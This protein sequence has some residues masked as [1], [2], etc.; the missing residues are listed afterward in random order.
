MKD[1]K[2]K[3]L[4]TFFMQTY[5]DLKKKDYILGN[6]FIHFLAETWLRSHTDVC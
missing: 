3:N 5:P 1:K 4:K 2:K 6:K